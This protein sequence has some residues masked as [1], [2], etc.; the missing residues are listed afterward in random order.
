MSRF[1]S[2]FSR[3]VPIYIWLPAVAGCAAGGYVASSLQPV[4]P[5][6]STQDIPRS[7]NQAPI[8]YPELLPVPGP[9]RDAP[10]IA[11]PTDEADHATP[12]ANVAARHQ[13][14]PNDVG[15]SAPPAPATKDSPQRARLV[16]ADR[17]VARVR[18]PQ[19]TV[20]QPVKLPGTPSASLK[21]VP[22]IGP[23]FSMFQ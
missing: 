8:T 17:P 9:P 20:Q 2:L 16:R 4:H 5:I 14:V 12:V 15:E 18:R 13:K 21:N 6:P 3:R 7:A 10:V 1:T 22:I 23:V 19:R 11:L